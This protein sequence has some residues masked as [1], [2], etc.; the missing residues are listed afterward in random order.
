M[1]ELAIYR[2]EQHAVIRA[3]TIDAITSC[4]PAQWQQ[5][6]S[7]GYVEDL[8]H[9]HSDLERLTMTER[10]TQDSMTRAK[11]H[12]A[13]SKG[14]FL[15][16]VAKYSADE[17][18]RAKAINELADLLESKATEKVRR[19]I[20]WMWACVAIRRGVR[21]QIATTQEQSK[22]TFHRRRREIFKQLN[23][24][25]KQAVTDVSVVLSGVCL[26]R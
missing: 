19:L 9:K 6:Y 21:E 7:S 8:T 3:M 13:V 25:E 12:R 4:K 14:S 5:Q 24:W 10:L 22:V 15:A 26:D 1:S 16:I 20:I 11:I 23:D 18:E 17:S 2:D